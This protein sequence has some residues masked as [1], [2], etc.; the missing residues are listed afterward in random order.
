MKKFLFLTQPNN[1]PYF[2]LA[3]EEYLLYN[4]ADYYVYL[5]VNSPAVIVGVNQNTL[6]EVNLNYTEEKGIKVGLPIRQPNRLG[7]I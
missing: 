7:E 5:W 1:D 3:S 4:K 2:N 6:E